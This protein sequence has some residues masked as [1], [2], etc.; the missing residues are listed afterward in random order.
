MEIIALDSE[1]FQK[2][3]QKVDEIYALLTTS[4]QNFDIYEEWVESSDVS[5][6]L[7]VSE[8]TLQRLR[9]NQEISYTP[10]HG[11]NFYQIREINRMLKDKLIRSKQKYLD[12]LIKDHE[13]RLK[14]LVKS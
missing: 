11:K 7:K 1:A 5:K 9:A 2:L 12:E 13:A 4:S 10:L 6:C 14:Q 8:R 3:I